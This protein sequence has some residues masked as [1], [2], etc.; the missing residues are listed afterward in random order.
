MNYDKVFESLLKTGTIY[1]PPKDAIFDF[2][3]SVLRRDAYNC[4]R[5]MQESYDSG[6]ATLVMISNLYSNFKALLQVQSCKSRDISN[7]T[8]L[9]GWQISNAKKYQGNYTIGELIDAMAKTREAEISMKTGTMDEMVII[10][11][12][13]VNIL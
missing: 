4:F 1:Q 8:G 11:H 7:C 5:L 2:V 3:D 10:P 6:E 13:L 9:I 12:L